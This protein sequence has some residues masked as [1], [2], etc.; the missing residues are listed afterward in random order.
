MRSF[1][2]LLAALVCFMFARSQDVANFTIATTGRTITITNTSQFT[3]TANRK[4]V[5]SFGDGYST[6]TSSTAG[7][8]HSYTANG[9]FKV[10]LI[11]Y[12]YTGEHDSVATADH[13]QEVRISETSTDYMARFEVGKTNDSLTKLF[14]VQINTN[15]DHRPEQV[16]W[17]FG[18]GSD[19]CIQYNPAE[20]HNYGVYHHYK[21]KGSYKACV[22]ILY[23]GGC[24]ADTCHEV[25]VNKP[26]SCRIEYK[27]EKISSNR[28]ALQFIAFPVNSDHKKPLRLCWKFGDG[29]DTCIEYAQG[30]EKP[31]SVSHAYAQPGNYEACVAVLFDGGCEARY[32]HQ[33]HIA[34]I[35]PPPGNSC[36]I[37]IGTTTSN[38]KEQK[39]YAQV[40]AN[41][42][43]LKI[44]W[45]FGDGRDTCIYLEHPTREGQ[46]AMIH[47][48]P[49]PGHYELC[50]K[51]W[52]DGGCMAQKCRVVDIE[53]QQ[54]DVCGGYMAVSM[55]GIKKLLFKGFSVTNPSDHAI[56]WRWN[57]GDGHS[58]DGQVTA[59][60]Y[61]AA[62]NYRV[63]LSILTD[64]GCETRVCKTIKVTDDN[65]TPIVQLS[66]NP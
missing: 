23:Q 48:Y 34:E 66:P 57:F 46:L 11:I 65:A 16:C 31:F 3:G 29:R 36:V 18:D 41:K 25:S 59:H 43:P 20:P 30:T 45:N 33:V 21:E 10:C 8:Q 24:K 56:S 40:E 39:F 27:T 50:V 55:T 22:K 19:T 2:L 12:V 13:C 1:H 51:V 47:E 35:T 63:C 9:A 5:W 62:G 49:G 26:D 53:G 54:Y 14:V 6:S 4:A 32:C 60:E 44:C 52:Y 17:S 37:G 64:Q 15:S 7:T 58:G 61:D 42:V 28:M 38:G